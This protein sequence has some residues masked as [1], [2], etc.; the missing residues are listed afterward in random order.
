MI[1]QPT[2]PL[3]KSNIFK[4][5]RRRWSAKRRWPIKRRRPYQIAYIQPKKRKIGF[6]KKHKMVEK[7]FFDQQTSYWITRFLN[8]HTDL[9]PTVYCLNLVTQ[10]TTVNT[11]VGN[12]INMKSLRLKGQIT[13]HESDTLVV[14]TVRL[15]VG[16]NYHTNRQV[17]TYGDILE[18]M[19]TTN[20]DT[21][22]SPYKRSNLGNFKILHDKLY[23]I[24]MG[25]DV[26]TRDVIIQYKYPETVEIDLYFPLNAQAT[27]TQATPTTSEHVSRN[28]IFA[29]MLS[30]STDN[31]GPYGRFSHSVSF[32]D[33]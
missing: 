1:L 8:Q 7:K 21:L 29:L 32:T 22:F 20:W 3:K 15:I 24:G 5:Y 11:R 19:V 33:T 23:K 28:A 14:T 13:K 30:N 4:M 26:S 25:D 17:T 6:S 27:F 2:F 9:T 31:Y 16:I 10:G 18:T 12:S